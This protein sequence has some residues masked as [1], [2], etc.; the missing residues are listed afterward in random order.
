MT[1]KKLTLV[2]AIIGLMASMIGGIIVFAAL[3]ET[4][5]IQG[6]A[7]FQ[8]ATWNVRF[9]PNSLTNPTL[10]NGG[11]TQTATVPTLPTLTDT[12]VGNFHVVLTQPGDS[13]RFR[14]TIENIGTLNAI[15][16][17]YSPQTPS[18]TG[19]APTAAA[20]ELIVCGPNLTYV[21]RYI[22][23]QLT[24][25]GLT[26]GATV[27]QGDRLNAGTSVQV[28]LVL[29][30]SSAATQLPANPVTIGNLGKTLIYTV[31]NT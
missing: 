31:N 13:A 7:E 22:G 6:T 11:L 21:F 15:L 3:S 16:S 23:G 18:C 20:D 1:N 28:E 2:V 12:L 25:N 5:E 4:L 14:F 17:T 27:T 29:T 26:N 9:Q 24:E 19:T 8:P 10:A 30:Y